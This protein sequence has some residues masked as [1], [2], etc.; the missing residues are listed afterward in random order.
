M[1][2]KKFD[3]YM[4]TI[5]SKMSDSEEETR[6]K[7]KKKTKPKKKRVRKGGLCMLIYHFLNFLWKMV[8]GTVEEIEEKEEE[9]PPI[10]WKDIEKARSDRAH[11]DEI[12]HMKLKEKEEKAWFDK[13]KEDV[14]WF[15]KHVIIAPKSIKEIERRD[16]FNERIKRLEED[17]QWN[18]EYE[19]YLEDKQK[20]IGYDVDVNK[21]IEWFDQNAKMAFENI[22]NSANDNGDH[23]YYTDDDSGYRPIGNGIHITGS[24]IPVIYTENN[25]DSE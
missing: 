6:P 7:P 1:I 3:L 25:S 23:E 5:I 24:S 12:K 22:D 4:N 15:Y 10:T 13:W 16:A 21:R 8:V 19:D 17:K 11:K 18:D 9:E 14:E 2:E 20:R